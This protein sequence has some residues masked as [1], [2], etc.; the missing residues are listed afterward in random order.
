MKLYL[1]FLFTSLI[2]VATL[3]SIFLPDGY[4]ILSMWLYTWINA[5]II[6]GL[7]A[8]I[9]TLI[10]ALPR[11]WFDPYNKIFHIYKWENKFL[12][13]GMKIMKWKDKIPELGKLTTNFSKGSID[14]TTPEYLYYFLVETCYAGCIHLFMAL[15]GIIIIFINPIDLSICIMLPLVIINFVLNIPPIL[16]QRL[17]RPKLL[18]IYELELRKT[19]LKKQSDNIVVN[20]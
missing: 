13:N 6:F 1:S 20:Q 15:I 7:D 11:K 10:H 2:I 8:L 3:N 19:S 17:N 16:I 5:V 4:S 12:T 14:N 18:R 9:A